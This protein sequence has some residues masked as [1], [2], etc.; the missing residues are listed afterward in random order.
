VYTDFKMSTEV[1][2][3]EENRFGLM[4]SE[5]KKLTALINCRMRL[6]L[7]SIAYKIRSRPTAASRRG[8]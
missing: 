4:M 5:A 8:C 2:V 6:L 1:P 3:D 7:R